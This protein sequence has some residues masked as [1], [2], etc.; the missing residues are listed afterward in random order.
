MILC[1]RLASIPDRRFLSSDIRIFS[2]SLMPNG[3]T[4]CSSFFIQMQNPFPSDEPSEPAAEE[5]AG[6]QG[7][8]PRRKGREHQLHKTAGPAA[9]HKQTLLISIQT[10]TLLNKR[11]KSAPGLSHVDPF[12]IQ[13]YLQSQRIT[14]Y[15]S[16]T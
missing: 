10:H 13:I 9:E 15:H 16:E 4:P 7:L 11:Q 14:E 12:R 5:G 1:S 3:N 6:L 8:R 2:P